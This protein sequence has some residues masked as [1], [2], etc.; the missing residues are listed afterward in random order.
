MA[1]DNYIPVGLIQLN[2]YLEED[3]T[4]FRM[5]CIDFC[6]FTSFWKFVYILQDE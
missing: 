6:C 5:Q 1:E 4:A 2:G 3:A